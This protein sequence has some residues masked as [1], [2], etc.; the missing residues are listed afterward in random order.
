MQFKEISEYK[1]YQKCE[2]E[3]REWV[4]ANYTGLSIEFYP[5]IEIVRTNKFTEYSREQ[6]EKVVDMVNFKIAEILE[7]HAEEIY[8]AS[9]AKRVAKLHP[10]YDVELES[11]QDLKT[12]KAFL[13]Y[14]K[15]LSRKEDKS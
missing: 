13:E 2:Q 5:H 15:E 14:V 8:I 10:E 1:E 11:L 3:I 12:N 6:A 7:K 4:E 9:L